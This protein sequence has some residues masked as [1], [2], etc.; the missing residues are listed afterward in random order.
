MG[1]VIE[2]RSRNAGKNLFDEVTQLDGFIPKQKAEVDRFRTMLIEGEIG[3]AHVE[4]IMKDRP[5][6]QEM[7]RKIDELKEHEKLTGMHYANLPADRIEAAHQTVL[8]SQK[9]HSDK[10]VEKAMEGVYEIVEGTSVATEVLE[11]MQQGLSRKEAEKE[12]R[13]ARS[14]QPKKKAL[15]ETTEVQDKGKRIH[16][17]EESG[18]E[19]QANMEIESGK[20]SGLTDETLRSD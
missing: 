19:Q 2:Q 3:K 8:Q 6:F 9:E 7:K 11:L 12:A 4:K 16:G 20:E 18:A 15:S 13:L 1:I 10:V 14:K 17:T 5:M